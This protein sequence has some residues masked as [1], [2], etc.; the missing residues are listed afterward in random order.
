MTNFI[1]YQSNQLKRQLATDIAKAK[2]F[3]VI[4]DETTDCAV[5]EQEAIFAIYFDCDPDFNNATANDGQELMV[6]VQMGFLSVKNLTTISDIE[7][8]DT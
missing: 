5:V 8:W 7:R 6:K 2:F 4:F 1:L 3:S